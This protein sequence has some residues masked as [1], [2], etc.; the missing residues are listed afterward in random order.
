MTHSDDFARISH[1]P[2]K[3]GHVNDQLRSSSSGGGGSKAEANEAEEAMGGI[4]VAAAS[5]GDNSSN[6]ERIVDPP[7]AHQTDYEFALRLSPTIDPSLL[8]HPGDRFFVTVEAAEEKVSRALRKQRKLEGEEPYHS[9]TFVIWIESAVPKAA[10]PRAG[11]EARVNQAA[12]R[13]QRMQQESVKQQVLREKVQAE[14]AA[15]RRRH[16]EQRV[17]NELAP[18]LQAHRATVAAGFEIE[19]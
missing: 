18:D 14:D 13:A 9:T 3:G 12:E 6:A 2:Q 5:G 11:N 19:R 8:S 4:D 15:R 16:E 7:Y 1:D 10:D 17:I